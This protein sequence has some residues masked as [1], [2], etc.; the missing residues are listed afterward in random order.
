MIREIVL[1]HI[2]VISGLVSFIQFK[3]VRIE[4]F[5]PVFTQIS[6]VCDIF[7]IVM[8]ILYCIKD[9]STYI[10]RFQ[11]VLWSRKVPLSV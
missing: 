2:S 3:K 10:C 6:Q 8:K 1:S 4:S 9:E 11:H 7:L 5:L